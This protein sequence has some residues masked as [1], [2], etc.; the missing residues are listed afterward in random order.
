MTLIHPCN[1]LAIP[2]D[3]ARIVHKLMLSLGYHRYAIQAG[4]WGAAVARHLAMMYPRNVA[5]V[6]LNFSPAAPPLLNPPLLALAG[7]CIPS[8]IYAIASALTPSFLSR[9]LQF[10]RE[11]PRWIDRSSYLQE[12]TFMSII[13]HVLFGLPAPLNKRDISRVRRAIDFMTSGS[14]Y[15]AMQGTRPST[16]GLA[17]QSDPGAQLA[18]IG[19]KL[20]QWTDEECVFPLFSRVISR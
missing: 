15:S 12:P 18:W 3:E 17:M 11:F 2:T 14:A 20:L 6:H 5:A 10:V 4:D 16:L 13:G 8:H 1:C 19:E 7:R 9:T